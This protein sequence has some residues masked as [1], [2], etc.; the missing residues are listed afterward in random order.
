MF[1]A[2][3]LTTLLLASCSGVPRPRLDEEPSFSRHFSRH[4]IDLLRICG[5]TIIQYHLD[6]PR[7]VATERTGI[8]DFWGAGHS[9]PLGDHLVA[10]CQNCGPRKTQ[11][12]P[13][14]PEDYGIS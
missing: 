7:H 4:S 12:P 2:S 9:S 11:A 6:H 13:L 8:V 5:K 3:L 1:V 10:Y 14:I